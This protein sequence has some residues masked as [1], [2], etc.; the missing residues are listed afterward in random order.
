MSLRVFALPVL[1]MVFTPRPAGAQEQ[2]RWNLRPNETL[3]YSV[4][5]NMKSTTKFG[6]EEVNSSFQQTI[7]MSWH[8]LSAAANGD[9]IL[10]QVFDRVRLQM[11]GG[12]A[13]TIEFDTASQTTQD[14]PV[15]KALSDV[16]GNIVGQQFKVI[17]KQTGQIEDVIVPEKLAEAVRQS[18]A[19]QQGALTDKMLKDMMKQSAVM[20]PAQPVGPGSQWTS[21]QT[22]QM[23]FGTMTITSAMK[24]VQKDTEGNAIIDFVP[25]VRITP[26]EGAQTSMTLDGSEGRG[27]VNF[28]ISRGRVNQTQLDLKLQMT[29]TVNGQKLPQTVHNVT[30]MTLIP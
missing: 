28:D 10:N 15:L 18:A 9:T 19:G 14:N 13:G 27:R 26:R 4:V 16:F 22:V 20:L 1:F 17:M 29:M 2:L 11:A 6:D 5:Q 3:R 21:E 23:P 12:P 30:S 24:F 7:D 8:V 25:T